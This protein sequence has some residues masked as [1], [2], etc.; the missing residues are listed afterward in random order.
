MDSKINY[1][2]CL[3]CGSAAISKVFDCIDY[4]VSNEY[5]EIWKCN[6]CTF[7]FTQNAPGEANISTYY[8]SAEYIS[9]SNTKHGLVNRLYHYVRSFTLTT[10]LN[11]IEEVTGLKHGVLL[12]V[13]AG[14]GAFAFTMQQA[15]WNVTGLEPDETARTNGFNNYELQLEE[16]SNL[17]H[18]PDDTFDAITLWHVLEHVHDLHGYLEK[19]LKILKPVGRLVIAVPNFTSYDANIY[20]QYWA[21]YDVPRH[22]YHFSPKSIKILLEKKG[23]AVEAF[24]PMWFDSFYVSMLSEKYRHGKNSFINAVW[25]GLL[26]NIK[27]LF[28]TQRCSSVIYVVRKK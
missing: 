15:G 11:L 28:N 27:A 25:V 13:G 20:R 22:L 9:H 21:A 19:F 26:S 4:T 7:R 10:K 12:D 24:K 1:D 17:H 5:F 18:L 8:Q 14:T 3:C 23:F 6:T 2:H 16:L